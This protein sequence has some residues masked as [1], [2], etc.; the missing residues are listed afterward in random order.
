MLKRSPD[1]WCDVCG[2]WDHFGSGSATKIRRT[3]KAKGWTRRLEPLR[4]GCIHNVYQD[5]CP[6]CLTKEKPR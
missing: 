4:P 1:L 6:A 5:V 3:A 2:C